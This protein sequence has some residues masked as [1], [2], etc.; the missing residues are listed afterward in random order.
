MAHGLA[1]GRSSERPRIRR[2]SR[3]SRRGPSVLDYRTKLPEVYASLKKELI[4]HFS[5]I[6]TEYPGV[7][8]SEIIGGEKSQPRRSPTSHAPKRPSQDQFFKT[9]DRNGDGAITLEEFIGNP[10][11][12]NVPALTKRFKKIDSNGDGKLQPAELGVHAE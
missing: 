9:R 8:I 5:N 6:N 7:G 1:G 12:R 11:G 10:E 3:V 4:D 2:I